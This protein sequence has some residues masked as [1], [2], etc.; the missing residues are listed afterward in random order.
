MKIFFYPD[1]EFSDNAGDN[2]EKRIGESSGSIVKFLDKLRIK[3]PELW[4]LVKTTLTNAQ[5][6]IL[7]DLLKRQSWIE[8]LVGTKEPIHEFRIP[9]TKKGGV[10]R[11]YFGYKQNDPKTIFILSAELKK[12]TETNN[13]RIKQAEQRYKEVCL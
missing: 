8:P 9:P 3:R 4:S 10:V 5:N 6:D 1:F 13:E 12:N 2:L 11:L 7:F